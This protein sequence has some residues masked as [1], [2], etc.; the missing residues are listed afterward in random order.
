MQKSSKRG[1][2][3]LIELMLVTV[4][5]VVLVILS[6]PLFT[7]TYEDLKLTTAAREMAAVIRF[8]HER[9]IFEKRHY[10]LVINLKEGYYRVYIENPE[11]EGMVPLRGRWGRR[12]RLPVSAK[13][14]T[15]IERIDCLP[16]GYMTQSSIRI[17]TAKGNS[18]TILTEEATGL[19]KV[20][21]HTE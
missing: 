10:R 18:R 17:N 5:I 3:T 19:V 13:F 6:T 8:C 7:R 1:A 14:E 11:G 16:D 12:F 4:I 20:Y 9:A 2:F 21:D 15:E